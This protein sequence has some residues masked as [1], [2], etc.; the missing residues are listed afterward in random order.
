[1]SYADCSVM[2]LIGCFCKDMNACADHCYV[3][4]EQLIYNKL[5]FKLVINVKYIKYLDSYYFPN[6]SLYYALTSTC[7]C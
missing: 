6:L 4:K 2:A 3:W 5:Y 7:G 1:M